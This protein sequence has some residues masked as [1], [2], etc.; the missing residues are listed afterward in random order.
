M[1]T[2]AE[3]AELLRS[4]KLSPVELTRQCLDRIARLNPTLNAFITITADQALDAAR[5]AEAEIAAGNYRGPLHGIPPPEYSPPPPAISI[6]S[7][8]QRKMPK[9]SAVSSRAER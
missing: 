3:A 5:R 1:F 8:F 9:L 4:R 7:G 2:L 6:A